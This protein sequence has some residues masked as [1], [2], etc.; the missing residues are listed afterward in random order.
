MSKHVVRPTAVIDWTTSVVAA[1]ARGLTRASRRGDSVPRREPIPN[2][3]GDRKK[4][5]PLLARPR[6]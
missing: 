3:S 5:R 4:A 2:R 1:A 6:P